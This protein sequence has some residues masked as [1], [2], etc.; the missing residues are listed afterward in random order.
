[1]GASDHIH[2]IITMNPVLGI[3]CRHQYKYLFIIGKNSAGWGSES[4]DREGPESR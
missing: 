3:V 2:T 1:M 4:E